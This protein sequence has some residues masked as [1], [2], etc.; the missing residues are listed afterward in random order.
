MPDDSFAADIE[1]LRQGGVNLSRLSDTANS[2][3]TELQ[4]ECAG[5]SFGGD[6]D[7]SKALKKNYK[8]GEEAGLEFLQNLSGAL[9][10]DGEDVVDTSQA[11]DDADSTASDQADINGRK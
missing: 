5:F 3:L 4:S 11:F 8:P 6:D 1:A 7:I 9:D 2:I 10:T